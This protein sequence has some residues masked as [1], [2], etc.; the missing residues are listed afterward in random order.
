MKKH[1]LA[2]VV[3]VLLPAGAAF[4]DAPFNPDCHLQ[5]INSGLD[6]VIAQ[7]KSSPAFGYAGG[8]YAS[9]LQDL[10]QTRK[11]LHQGCRAWNKS[12]A[13]TIAGITV[14]GSPVMVFN[15]KDK[16]M[17]WNI[18][19]GPV[20]AW[21]E[22]NGRISM[23]VPHF[24][25]YRMTGPDLEDLTIDPHAI[26]SSGASS[27]QIP[28]HDSNYLQWLLTPYTLDGVTVHMLTHMEWYGCLLNNDC[29]Q[30]AQAETNSWV[31]SVSQMISTDGGENF[32]LDNTGGSHV[33]ASPG[34]HWTG[35][36]ALADKIYLRA[37]NHTGIFAT[38]RLTE[39]G[40]YY[41]MVGYLILRDFSNVDPTGAAPISKFGFVLLRSN[42]LSNPGGWQGWEGAGNWGPASA[43]DYQTFLPM[44]NGGPL[45]NAAPPQI[46][47]DTKAQC[48]ILIFTFFGGN[49]A[50]YYTTTKSL[51]A[52]EWSDTKEVDG[53][54]HLVTDPAGSVEGFSDLNYISL[55]DDDS[56]GFNFETTSGAPQLFY[57]TSPAQYDATKNLD[58]DIYRVPLNISYQ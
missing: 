6:S 49:N 54:A 14:T 17:K 28:E 4:S 48:Y 9:A 52:P 50:V 22:T 36:E 45:D 21:R 18:P 1:S 51:A 11:Q 44:H 38:S 15:H 39:E 55:L 47:Y 42:D 25:N 24:E 23:L 12:L 58:R 5:G 35:T 53:T 10:E 27:M 32:R 30:T 29:D 46:V 31:S 34:F 33:A 57:N 20:S 43:A 41:Y 40:H 26:F 8:H 19:D 37:L 3:G 13:K 16:V 7:I 2:I 56:A